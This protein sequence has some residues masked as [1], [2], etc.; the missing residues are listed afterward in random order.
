MG[1]NVTEIDVILSIDDNP[2]TLEL[3]LDSVE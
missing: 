2:T 3:R 1:V